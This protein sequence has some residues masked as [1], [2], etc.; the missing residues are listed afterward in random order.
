MDL[1][2]VAEPEHA[3][4]AQ[5]PRRR[6]AAL[7]SFGVWEAAGRTVRARGVHGVVW[8]LRRQLRTAGRSEQ[9]LVFALFI[10]YSKQRICIPVASRPSR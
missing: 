6:L 8:I 10:R 7:R 1:V 2:A 3:G 5:L 4:R 9:I